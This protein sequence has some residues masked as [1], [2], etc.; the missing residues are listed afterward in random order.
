MANRR[1]RLDQAD[2]ALDAVERR[3]VVKAIITPEI[4]VAEAAAPR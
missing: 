3:D 1:Y 4:G 2:A